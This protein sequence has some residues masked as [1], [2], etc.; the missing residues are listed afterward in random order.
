MALGRR[1]SVQQQDLFITA[2][3]L[4]RSVGHVFYTKL[5]RLLDEAGF[6]SWIEKLCNPYYSQARGRPGIPPGVYFRML[7]VGYFEG[8]QSQRGIAWR[9][10]DSLSIRQFLGLKLTDHSPDHS[11][12]TVIRERLPDTVH[13]SVFEWVLKLASEKK[14]LGGKTVAVDSTTLEA[15]AAMKSIVRRD[16]GEDW[17]SYVIGLMRA[18]GLV[19]EN[20]EPS[21]EEIRRFDK[22]RKGKKVSNEDWVSSTDPSAK[23]ARMKDGTTHLA[24]KAEHVVDMK[25]GMILGA[26]VTSADN[27]DSQSLEDSLHKAQIHL[28][29]AGSDT[30]IQEVAADKGYHS[31]ETLSELAEH[32]NYRTYI[33]EPK[34]PGGRKWSK[35]T[36]QQRQAVLANRRRAKGNKGRK[37]QRSRS[38]KVERTFAHLL[39]TG[40]GRRCRLRGTVKIQKRYFLMT[41]AY[42]LGVVMRMLFGVGTSRSLQGVMRAVFSFFTAVQMLYEAFPIDRGAHYRADRR[43]RNRFT[44]SE[45]PFQKLSRSPEIAISSTGC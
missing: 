42:N 24:Y 11:S 44:S 38:E 28:N 8:I 23:I 13:E 40:G 41:A 6:D 2:E 1:K 19:K 22:N 17:R 32:T 27:P 26:E 31:T 30:E 45:C 37:L 10:A 34:L 18:E 29:E 39:E 25:S 3:D 4:P 14:L 16:T 7:L 33:P 9:C 12:L 43:I 21:D 20:E 36:C 35:Y 15:D 5:N